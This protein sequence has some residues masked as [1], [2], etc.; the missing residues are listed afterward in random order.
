MLTEILSAKALQLFIES[1]SK[2]DLRTSQLSSFSNVRDYFSD[3]YTY[4]PRNFTRI[5]DPMLAF[6]A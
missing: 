1:Q 4:K 6:L 3:E 5:T 2:G